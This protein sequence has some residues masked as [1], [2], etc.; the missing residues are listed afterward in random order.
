MAPSNPV[1]FVRNVLGAISEAWNRVQ[2]EDESGDPINAANPLQIGGEVI[3][4]GEAIVLLASAVRGATAGTNGTPVDIPTRLAFGILLT[5]TNKAT[6]V[7][8][9]CD[10]YVDMLI[11]STWVNAIHF[12]QALGNAADASAQYALLLPS[13]DFVTLDVS[14]NAA[15]GVVRP[16]V[17]GSQMRARWVIVDPGAGVASFTFGIEIWA[18]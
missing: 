2:L 15:S 8:D 3:S 9:T 1:R 7:T 13:E 10:V 17:I 11:G 5:F 16:N 12:T 14:T 4:T 18:I 6:D